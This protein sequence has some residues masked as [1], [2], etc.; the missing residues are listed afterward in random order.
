MDFSDI[1]NNLGQLIHLLTSDGPTGV[2]TLLVIFCGSCGYW[3]IKTWIKN[4]ETFSKLEIEVNTLKTEGEEE[5]EKI[6][7][8]ISDQ[9]RTI[10]DLRVDFAKISHSKTST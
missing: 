10:A 3:H 5:R 9:D 8:K 4:S 2:I 1:T 6:K 7:D